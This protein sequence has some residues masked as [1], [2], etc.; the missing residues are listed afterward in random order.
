[1]K[2][3]DVL[4]EDGR[5][6]KGVNTTVDVGVDQTKIEAGKF[7]NQVTRDGFPPFLRTDGK[8]DEKKLSVMEQACIEGGHDVND[9]YKR[10]LFDWNKY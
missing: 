2:I 8:V 7:G 4:T 10:K 3:S 5:I 1:M 9:L 6:V